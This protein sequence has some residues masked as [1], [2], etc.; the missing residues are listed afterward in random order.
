MELGLQWDFYN[1]G[2]FEAELEWY[3]AGVAHL[4]CARRDM[5]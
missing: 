5:L 3:I 4:W 2:G 1:R